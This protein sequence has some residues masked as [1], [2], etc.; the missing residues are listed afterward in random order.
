[1]LAWF[2][3]HPSLAALCVW[4]IALPV[5]WLIN[6]A[7]ITQSYT[8][9]FIGV[10]N[11]PPV[12]AAAH[13]WLDW[14]PVL[15]WWRLRR[16]S[17][18]H[19]PSFWLRP[20]LVEL[21]FPLAMVWLYRAEVG[22]EFLPT[23]RLA[24]TLQAELHCQ[25]CAHFMLAAFMLVAT[26]IDYDEQM[27]PDTITL[28]GTLLA[29]VGSAT[30]AAWFPFIPFVNSVEETHAASISPWPAWLDGPWGLAIGLLIVTI[31]CFALLD[32]AWITRRGLKKAF[33]YLVAVIFRTAWWR[34]VALLWI[35]CMAAVAFAW[36]SQIPRWSFL[37]SALLGMATAAGITW[38]VRIAARRG[39]GVEAL[40]F[41]DVT[42][43][44]MIGC[45]LGWQASLLV[46]FV[47]PLIG[48]IFF[49]ARYVIWREG[50]G[51]YGPYLCMATACILLYW[52]FFRATYLPSIMILPVWMTF[53]ILGGSVVLMA[54]VLAVWRT[55]SDRVLGIDRS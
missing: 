24:A 23:T 16:E 39:L 27:I 12:G 18:Y 53:G 10:W 2:I 44:A 6:W 32:R 20:F 14:I 34:I 26:L 38:A 29:L 46:F 9:Q 35:V 37:L 3:A 28:P 45:Y 8:R 33:I 40:G 13:G 7:T 43:M 1:M 5:A 54:I 50:T 22:G 55:F 11:A 15:G 19:S 42:L 51:P 4:L 25:F 49:G 17:R 41:G 47:A 21:C 36:Q 30:F 48:V 31:W 52:N